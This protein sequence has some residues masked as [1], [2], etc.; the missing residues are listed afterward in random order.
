M[1]GQLQQLSLTILTN[2]H[3]LENSVE[4]SHHSLCLC[5]P[6]DDEG[7]DRVSHVPGGQRGGV[8]NTGL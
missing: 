3:C 6:T 5:F 2:L 4:V 1:L 7:K 8:N